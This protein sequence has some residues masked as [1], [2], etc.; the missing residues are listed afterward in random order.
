MVYLLD[1]QSGE[2]FYPVDD[3]PTVEEM[4][5]SELLYE[6][7]PHYRFGSE[8]IYT[9][10]QKEQA[11]YLS[12]FLIAPA[13]VNPFLGVARSALDLSI[14]VDD[15]LDALH[16]HP[17]SVISPVDG[18]AVR[19]GADSVVRP[20]GFTVP[21]GRCPSMNRRGLGCLLMDNHA[22]GHVYG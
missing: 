12:A 13:R 2:R 6:P 16:P 9:D 15:I 5:D 20:V 17:V 4:L 10:A 8:H 3:I 7:Q 1:P 18:G 21:R 14:R 22:G 19:A 11:R